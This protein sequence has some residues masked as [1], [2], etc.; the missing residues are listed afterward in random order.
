MG[1]PASHLLFSEAYVNV[2]GVDDMLMYQI[3][4]KKGWFY[5][6]WMII[7]WSTYGI[8]VSACFWPIL[9]DLFYQ[10]SVQNARSAH[11]LRD[12]ILS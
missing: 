6:P 3:N 9:D 7:Y 10:L 4:V 1:S 5:R 2:R 8:F 11:N 12:K